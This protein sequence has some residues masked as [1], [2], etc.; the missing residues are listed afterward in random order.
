[1]EK[2]FKIMQT[3]GWVPP[4]RCP[5]DR[6][7]CIAHQRSELQNSPRPMTIRA[8]LAAFKREPT[9]PAL[10]LHCFLRCSSH[11]R[12]R[13][14]NSPPHL[15][16][17]F[18]FLKLVLKANSASFFLGEGR[19]LFVSLMISGA[20]W[21]QSQWCGST[22]S[23]HTAGLSKVLAANRTLALAR[24]CEPHAVHRAASLRCVHVLRCVRSFQQS[25]LSSFGRYSA[26]KGS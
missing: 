23:S 22:P 3:V 18:S 25:S 21:E 12:L 11:G 1:M 13:A 8:N 2:Q 9:L 19:F 6:E 26:R 15:L 5:R 14:Q 24:C 4:E 20:R 17:Q 16:Q 7:A 10:R